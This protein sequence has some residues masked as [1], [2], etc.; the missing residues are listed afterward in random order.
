MFTAR[1]KYQIWNSSPELLCKYQVDNIVSCRSAVQSDES[2]F[3]L[4]SQMDLLYYPRIIDLL[5]RALLDKT[6]SS[7]KNLSTVTLFI[8]D[9]AW[10]YCETESEP[11]R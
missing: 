2:P 4:R 1:L 11:L 7:E 10:C 5:Y 6:V 9:L 3:V 8:K